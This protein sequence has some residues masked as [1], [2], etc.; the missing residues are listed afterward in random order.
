M[1]RSSRYL[2]PVPGLK[3]INDFYP[4]RIEMFQLLKFVIQHV[5]I[6]KKIFL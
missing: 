1:S 5:I 6:K 3:K 4:Q 2:N